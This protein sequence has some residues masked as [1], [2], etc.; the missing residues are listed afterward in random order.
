MYKNELAKG[1]KKFVVQD[2]DPTHLLIKVN[3][4]KEVESMV[5]AWQRENVYTSVDRV[6]EDLD[7][8]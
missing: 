5:E 3:A 4:R 6:G 7:V 2:L 8:S 1:D